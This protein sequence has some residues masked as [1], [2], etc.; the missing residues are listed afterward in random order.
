[1][2]SRSARRRAT[3]LLPAP[4]GP[5]IPTIM[6]ASSSISADADGVQHVEEVGEADGDRLGALDAHPFARD[7]PGDRGQHGD[8]VISEGSDRAPTRRAG[9]HPTNPEAIMTRLDAD[10]QGPE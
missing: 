5:S 3:V 1:M 4:A 10:S 6:A 9:R 8:A 2:P 7:Q